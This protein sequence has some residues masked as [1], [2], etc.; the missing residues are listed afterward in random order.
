M[1]KAYPPRP[2]FIE[3]GHPSAGG[4]TCFFLGEGGGAHGPGGAHGDLI[5]DCFEGGVKK[6]G[7]EAF[8]KRKYTSG[9]F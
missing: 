8:R 2:H 7:K 4:Q 6:Q 9:Y 3:I 5:L 1:P